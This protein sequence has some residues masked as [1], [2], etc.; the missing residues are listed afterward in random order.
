MAAPWLLPNHHCQIASKFGKTGIFETEP[1][2]L[3][4]V[5]Y[6]TEVA[7]YTGLIK[8]TPESAKMLDEPPVLV[9]SE[10]GARALTLRNGA[11]L[12]NLEVS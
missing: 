9:D 3:A 5:G 8:P 1:A 10:R 6:E 2:I 4:G 11:Y 7:V 12:H